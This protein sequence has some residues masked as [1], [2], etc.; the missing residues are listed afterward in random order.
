MNQTQLSK[1]WLVIGGVLT[2]YAL[3]TWIVGQGGNEIFGTKLIAS[4][5]VPAAVVA[6]PVCATLLTVASLVGRLYAVRGGERWHERVPV[7]GFDTLDTSQPEAKAYQAGMLF[8]FSLLPIAALVHFWR[9]FLL[10]DVMLNDG[11]NRL[12]G[13]IWDWQ[14]TLK[15]LNDPARICTAINA[16]PPPS[17]VDG[18][19]VLPGLEPWVFVLFTTVAAAAT[20]THWHA[21]LRRR[22]K[23]LAND[24]AT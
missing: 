18:V 14:P 3:N 10:A 17:C 16:G 24:D 2:Y 23:R 5:R 4:Q 19:T 15:S 13:S 21:V 12:L 7:V 9:V 1:I 11:S 6:I 20:A 22:P 8:M